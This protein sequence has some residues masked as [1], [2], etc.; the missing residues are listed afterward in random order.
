MDYFTLSRSVTREMWLLDS[1]IMS[2]VLG[3]LAVFNFFLPFNSSHVPN[4]HRDII[5]KIGTN[6]C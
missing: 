5:P 2:A 1:R 6:M 3:I 4:K